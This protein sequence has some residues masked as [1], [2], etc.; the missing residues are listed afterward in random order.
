MT[1][2]ANEDPATYWETR[3][4][5]RGQSWSGRPNA[6]LVA[7]AGDLTPGRALDL[8]CGEGGDA[9]W[10]AQQGWTV[11]AVDIS[12]AAIAWGSAH[13]ET[14]GVGERIAWVAADLADWRA[15]GHF[16][17]VSSQFLHSPVELPR[18]QIL[19]RAATA[20]VPGGVL[21]VIGH[22]DFPPWSSH[23]PEEVDLPTADEVLV[24][25][26][27]TPGGWTVLRSALVPREATGPDGTVATL[28]D[29][30]LTVRR[31]TPG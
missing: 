26:A 20:V 31:L 17:L 27:L 4:R 13:A 25:L 1:D 21:L 2:H 14:A 22:D 30:V 28:N 11:T 7:E 16:D 23:P 8:G 12:P 5:E 29:T 19:R 6:A 24:S 9:I 10:L 3:Y 18:E 15:E